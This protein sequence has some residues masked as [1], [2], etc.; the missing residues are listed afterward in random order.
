MSFLGCS[1]YGSRLNVPARWTAPPYPVPFLLSVLKLSTKWGLPDGRNCAI[2][3]LEQPD[4]EFPNLLKFHVSIKYNVPQ[5]VRPTFDILVSA[6]WEMGH[7]L[8]LS[9]YDLCP[10]LIDLVVKTRDLIGREQRR[11]ATIPPPVEHHSECRGPTRQERCKSAWVS[12]WVLNVG[13]QIVHV[14][15]LFR[16]ESYKSANVIQMLVVPGM[17]EGCLGLTKA[18]VL[19]GDAF[20]Y[21]YK[22]CTAALAQIAM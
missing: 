19:E 7:I 12:A 16:L 9:G 14:D 21:I 20:D 8:T 3:H 5:W 22:V 10:N 6:D 1:Y 2:Y 11:L 18:K 15:P 17:S 13:C 4:I